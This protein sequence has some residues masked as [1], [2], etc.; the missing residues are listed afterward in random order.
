MRMYLI[1]ILSMAIAIGCAKKEEVTPTP[2]G[3]NW[4]F[5]AP[6]PTARAWAGAV[7][8]KGKIYVV[9]GCSSL[10]DGQQFRNA[11]RS[12]EVYDPANNTWKV[13]SPMRI[14]R[15]GPAVAAMN[16]KIYVF[17]GFNEATWSANSTVEIYD[18]SSDTW[19]T[20]KDMPTPRSWARAVALNG[21]I[22]IIGG[23]GYGYR[24]DVEVYD[25]A[26][27]TWEVKSPILPRERYLHAA[28]AYNGKIYVIGGD[29]WEYGYQEIWDDIQEY[30]LI[31]DTW[32]KK[33]PM[34]AAATGLDAVV[35]DGKIYVFGGLPKSNVTW[36]YDIQSDRWEE[37][38]SNHSPESSSASFVFWNGYIFR[39][40]GG[41]WGPTL[42]IVESTKLALR[43]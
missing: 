35:V 12:L 25:P 41:G 17:G 23:V 38:P 27:N 16:G 21:K 42:N 3:L 11:V 8:Y 43:R 4:E 15:V 26:T 29:S 22:Y 34:P 32:V 40:G 30:D 24:R 37:I 5:K 1:L 28:V 33:S 6:M 13:L 2:T 18:I 19:A 20:G 39:F 9:G 14:P 7:V 31:T 10:S 36:V